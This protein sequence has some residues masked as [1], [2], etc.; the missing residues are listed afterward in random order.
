MARSAYAAV[1]AAFP[2]CLWNAQALAPT[3]ANQ[4]TKPKHP[5]KFAE[6]ADTQ[7]YWKHL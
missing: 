2:A 4:H 3:P 7:S 1:P 6:Q 5:E